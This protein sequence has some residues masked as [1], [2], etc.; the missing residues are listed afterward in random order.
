MQGEPCVDT[1]WWPSASQ[2]ERPTTRSWPRRQL[3]LGLRSPE[4]T[5]N[6]FVL[7]PPRLYS[8]LLWQCLP[9][10]A[11]A[12][13]VDWTMTRGVVT[14]WVGFRRGTTT[15]RMSWWAERRVAEKL[16]VQVGKGRS[17]QAER[18]NISGEEMSCTHERIRLLV[19]WGSQS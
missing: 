10:K 13:P 17:D 4:L 6:E 5:G 12:K 19:L 2:R 8:L 11:E 18:G 16:S 15:H 7:K 9:A 14:E 3:H 1:P